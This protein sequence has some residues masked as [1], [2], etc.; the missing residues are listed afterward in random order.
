MGNIVHIKR[1][2]KT[3]YSMFFLSLLL[4][5]C[6][7]LPRSGPD[8]D[9][10]LDVERSGEKS[11]AT[12]AITLV[13]LTPQIVTSI[14]GSASPSLGEI[15]GSDFH[16]PSVYHVRVGDR[17]QVRIWESSTDGLFATA[18][19]KTTEIPV[20][21]S[22]KG[23][24]HIPYAGTFEVIDLTLDEVRTQ[25]NRG[26]KGKAVD[27]EVAVSLLGDSAQNVSV[28]G[29]V[30][31]PNR[32]VIPPSGLRLLDAIAIAGGTKKLSFDTEVSV[33][34]DKKIVKVGLADVV[35]LPENNIWLMPN[36]TV[37]L[38]YRP[39]SFTAFGAVTSQ[40]LQEFRTEQVTLV[41]ALGQIGGLDV[42]LANA[43]GIFIFRFEGEDLLS[44]IGIIPR[45]P[46]I[47]TSIPTI[48]RLN[49]RDPLALHTAQKFQM[50]N[51]DIVYVA[52]S[53]AVQ[54]RKFIDLIIA[55]FLGPAINTQK[56]SN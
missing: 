9:D 44:K 6:A 15:L 13:N 47:F 8:G 51:K 30:S 50:R 53:E 10:I 23:T 36:D 52:T 48:Y 5:G 1:V 19:T 14:V 41:E 37:Q 54:F 18:T 20:V 55:P 34:R 39:R 45:K 31:S 3:V 24:I 25:L 26:L 33:V 22:P 17:L 42:N 12:Q 28:V 56:T 27:P 21:V 16:A 32:I 43:G 2:W 38:L 49:L 29:D 4:A 7:S 35:S 40:S 46:S 11:S